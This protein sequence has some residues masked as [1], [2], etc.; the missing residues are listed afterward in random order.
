MLPFGVDLDLAT[1]VLRDPAS[2]VVR[3]AS[4]M[5]GYYA[6]EEAL[7]R[8]IAAEDDPVHYEVFEAKVPEAAGHLACGIS[9]L[10][11][12]TVG[13]E[14]FMTKG[15]FHQEA[16]M[17]EIYLCIRGA[18]FMLMKTP[19][20]DRCVAEPMTRNRMV[21]VPPFWA[22]RSVNCGTEPL[23]SFYVYPAHAGHNYGDIA[24]QGFPRRIYRR[25]VTFTEGTPDSDGTYVIQ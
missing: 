23:V 16:G 6:D 7:Q 15:H 24:E 3:R 19:E 12:G 1:G 18:G 5:R 2:H 17:G 14:C 4:D 10:R 9:A 25:D 8:L 22:H 11:S 13:G 21:Y 20:G